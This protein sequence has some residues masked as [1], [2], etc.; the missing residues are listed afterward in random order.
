MSS[1]PST[2]S[3]GS[4]TPLC[5]TLLPA[6]RRVTPRGFVLPPELNWT[7]RER[8]STVPGRTKHVPC[9]ESPWRQC[10]K[11]QKLADRPKLSRFGLEPLHGLAAGEV[12]P[13]KSSVRT[14]DGVGQS[15]INAPPQGP[16]EDMM[17]HFQGTAG[18]PSWHRLHY[19]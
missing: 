19:P 12:Q 15:T 1:R 4:R 9:P 6:D 5:A 14:Y 8:P 7:P 18:L 11:A 2:T 16:S 10:A 13:R 3:F 17:R